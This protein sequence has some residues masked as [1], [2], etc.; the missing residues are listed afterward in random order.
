M[1]TSGWW[2]HKVSSHSV[3]QVTECDMCSHCVIWPGVQVSV[4]WGGVV[5]L[6]HVVTII[7]LFWCCQQQPIRGITCFWWTYHR[8]PFWMSEE[9]CLKSRHQWPRL[10]GCGCSTLDKC[11]DDGDLSLSHKWEIFSVRMFGV[12]NST[13]EILHSQWPSC[14]FYCTLKQAPLVLWLRKKFPF[15]SL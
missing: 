5:T 1:C 4:W 6:S 8:T 9:S 3:Y 7:Q 13:I 2:H 12:G 11:L 15:S 14:R 10:G